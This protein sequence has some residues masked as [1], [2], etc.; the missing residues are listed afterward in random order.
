MSVDLVLT[1]NAARGDLADDLRRRQRF[2]RFRGILS[3]SCCRLLSPRVQPNR[4]VYRKGPVADACADAAKEKSSGVAKGGELLH[5][6][7]HDGNSG[8]LRE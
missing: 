5:C 2:N 1:N 8:R 3:R 7:T 6:S 4:G